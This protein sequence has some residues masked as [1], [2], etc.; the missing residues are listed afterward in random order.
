[1]SNL[2]ILCCCVAM[3][4][5]DRTSQEQ[6]GHEKYANSLLPCSASIG[7]SRATSMLQFTTP[8]PTHLHTSTPTSGMLEHLLLTVMQIHNNQVHKVSRY[9]FV[10]P[11]SVP[12]TG[13][14]AR[15][16]FSDMV[17]CSYDNALTFVKALGA[18]FPIVMRQWYQVNSHKQTALLVVS[19]G[20]SD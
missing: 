15:S 19:H 10:A 8:T 7:Q 12:E 4:A 18:Y 14:R 5:V 2:L 20:G 11:I 6:T 9:F 17:Q 3:H 16:S 13:D 1:L